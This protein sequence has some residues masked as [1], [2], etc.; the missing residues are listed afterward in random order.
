MILGL[1]T[2]GAKAGEGQILVSN[3]YLAPYSQVYWGFGPKVNQAVTAA[4][5]LTFQIYFAKGVITDPSQM[6]VGDTFQIDNSVI[7]N[8]DPQEGHGPGGYFTGAIQ[9]LPNWTFGDTF[10]FMYEVITPG[11][12]GM[13]PFWQ[14]NANIFSASPLLPVGF[15]QSVGLIVVPE[16]TTIPLAAIGAVSFLTSR[17][18]T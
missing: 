8:I 17:R 10:T 3:Y 4:D 7:N 13:S 12:A 16:P 6:T 18:R 2:V 11:Y 15:S 5:G 9:L 14:E 1:V